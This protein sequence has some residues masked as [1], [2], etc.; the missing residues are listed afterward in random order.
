MSDDTTVI[1]SPQEDIWPDLKQGRIVLM[2]VRVGVD[3]RTGRVLVGWDHVV[4]SMATMF[5]TRFH[6]RVLRRWCG[7]FVPHL[8]GENA[9]SRVITRFYWAIVTAVDLW[10]PNYRIQHIGVEQRPDNTNLTSVEELRSGHLTTRMVGSYRPRA[11]L[12]DPTP[13]TQRSVSMANRGS[14]IW[15]SLV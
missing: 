10:E 1:Y 13:E 5:I 6:E 3:R 15:E 8:L 2:P 12:G 9:T 7:T 11:H 4:Q 14:G